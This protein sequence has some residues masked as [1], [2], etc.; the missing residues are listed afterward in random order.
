MLLLR[1]AG[2]QRVPQSVADEI[3]GE[4]GE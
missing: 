2:V 3:D 1:R 4:D